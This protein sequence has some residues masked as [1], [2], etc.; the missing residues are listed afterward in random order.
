MRTSQ[1]SPHSS[2]DSCGCFT[3]EGK[4]GRRTRYRRSF[5]VK[6]GRYGGGSGCI[7]AGQLGCFWRG[8]HAYFLYSIV[9]VNLVL[10]ED[11]AD[12]SP[13]PDLRGKAV[14]ELR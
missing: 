10:K 2:S 1:D 7:R 6:R 11:N 4:T 12:D 13:R 8:G 5:F 9:S 3:W 14:R